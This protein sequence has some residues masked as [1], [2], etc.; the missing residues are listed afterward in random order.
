MPPWTYEELVLANTV[1]AFR[2][3]NDLD[4]LFNHYGGIARYIFSSMPV[5]RSISFLRK[6]LDSFNGNFSSLLN[7]FDVEL[8][9]KDMFAVSSLLL[10]LI[11]SDDFISASSRW[12]SMYIESEICSR[13]R[14]GMIQNVKQFVSSVSHIPQ[15][16]SSRGLIFEPLAHRCLPTFS[17]SIRN[18]TDSS[19]VDFSLDNLS[20]VTFYNIASVT[21]IAITAKSYYVPTV[22]NLAAGDSFT[23]T[24]DCINI[25]QMTVS[26]THPVKGPRLRDLIKAIRVSLS[27]SSAQ[28]P[29]R[30]IFV[31]PNDF[32]NEFPLQNFQTVTAGGKWKPYNQIPPDLCSI[33]QFV[34]GIP[35]TE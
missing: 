28:I 32:K 21:T 25:F 11:P 30:L 19:E 27:D 26:A 16:S 18:L 3:K 35:L 5:D 24:N 15:F 9:D 10:H 17:G 34:M 1:F 6:T 7:A 33:D 22:P 31:V 14:V 8:V 12:G 20:L 4:N 2:P 23:F 13:H 29:V